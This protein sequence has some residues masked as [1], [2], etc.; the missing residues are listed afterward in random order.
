MMFFWTAVTYMAAFQVPTLAKS[1][2]A[3]VKA[4]G[5]LVQSFYQVFN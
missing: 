1:Y 3:N 2:V 4:Q 5:T